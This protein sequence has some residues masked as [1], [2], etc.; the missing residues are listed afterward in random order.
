VVPVANRGLHHLRD[1]RLDIAQKHAGRAAAFAELGKDGAG[2]DA[3]R[4]SSNLHDSL[5]GGRFPAQQQR[6][7]H[8]SVIA[9]DR[10]LRRVAVPQ[11]IE[12]RNDARD[13]EIHV[14]HLGPG[15]VQHRAE[16]QPGEGHVR[17]QSLEILRGERG[18]KTVLLR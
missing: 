3:V 1:Q 6:D 12:Q 9:D 2:L 17:Q 11:D 5:A 4:K 13:R 8:A 14:V 16:R 7:S 18:E 15:L 10:K